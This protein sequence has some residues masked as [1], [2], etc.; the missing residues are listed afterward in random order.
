MLAV[1]EADAEEADR[2]LYGGVGTVTGVLFSP[3]KEIFRGR[4][5]CC[6]YIAIG[7]EIVTGDIT[8]VFIVCGP[9]KTSRSRGRVEVVIFVR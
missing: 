3:A 1:L 5:G 2:D 6:G 9:T 4:R 8:A 7:S